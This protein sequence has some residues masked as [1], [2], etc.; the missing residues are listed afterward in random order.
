MDLV[1][2]APEGM[3]CQPG[4]FH[5]DP[6]EPV[7]RAV[8]THAHGDHARP[9]SLEYFCAEPSRPFLAR[10]LGDAVRIVPVPYGQAIRMG[11]SEVSFHPA[12]HVLGSAQ[13]R[14]A[15]GGQVWVVTG[16]YKRQPDTTCAPFEP[17][18]ADGLV[19][20]STFALPIYRWPNPSDVA[21][22]IFA[23]WEGNRARNRASVLFCYA[24][25]KAQRILSLLAG[26]TD[27]RVFVHGAIEPLTAIYRA[28]GVGMLPTDTVA[29]TSRGRSFAGEL[30]LAPELAIG[31]TWM[32]RFGSHETA[33]ASGWMRVRGNR[34]RRSFDRGFELSDHA[35]WPALL[36]TIRE[37]GARRILTTHGYAEPLARFLREQGFDADAV[38]TSARTEED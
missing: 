1:A 16:D 7:A 33:F 11:D 13:V 28:A 27:R 20:E 12:G 18:E 29:E 4:A 37:S 19:T 6:S 36:D 17:L 2:P 31:T 30:I 24:L 9:G 35:D 32:R 25:G 21:A 3:Y 38:T 14:V 34:R 5:I 8:V 22:D 23:W 10:R 26:L 15:H